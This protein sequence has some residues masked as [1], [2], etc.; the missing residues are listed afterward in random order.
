M[1]RSRLIAALAAAVAAAVVLAGG[2]AGASASTTLHYTFST[3]WQG[4]TFVAGL[5]TCPLFGAASYLSEADGGV[6]LTD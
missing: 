5:D 4:W 3:N 1:K 2:S 6:N